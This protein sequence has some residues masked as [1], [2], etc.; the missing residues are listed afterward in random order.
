MMDLRCEFPSSDAGDE[1]D[2][3][4][5]RHG[6]R[7]MGGRRQGH[8]YP[9]R[10]RADSIESEGKVSE[11]RRLEY[12]ELLGEMSINEDD[13]NTPERNLFNHLEIWACLEHGEVEDHE[14]ER[15][16][17]VF[18]ALARANSSFTCL[19]CK[20][21]LGKS[22]EARHLKNTMGAGCD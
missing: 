20:W 21:H 11:K 8:R 9:R 7:D 22:F 18:S 17:C 13:L 2:A 4:G 15:D 19:T 10:A 16:S 6:T 12:R 14:R 5:R 3:L 1:Q